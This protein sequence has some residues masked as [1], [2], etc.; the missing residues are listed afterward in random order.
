[1]KAD[2]FNNCR[3]ATSYEDMGSFLFLFSSDLI[4]PVRASLESRKSEG[5]V[6]RVHNFRNKKFDSTEIEKISEISKILGQNQIDLIFLKRK[7]VIINVK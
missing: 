7:N 2:N 4:S 1:M 5:I 3:P 6:G